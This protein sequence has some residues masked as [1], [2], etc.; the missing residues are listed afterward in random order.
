MSFDL[1]KLEAHL[2]AR[3]YIEGYVSLFTSLAFP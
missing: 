2:A 1:L 3:S